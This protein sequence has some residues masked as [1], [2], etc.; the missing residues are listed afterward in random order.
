M[1][2][3]IST[4]K[5]GSNSRRKVIVAFHITDL[6]AE[7]PF[8]DENFRRE[9]AIRIFERYFQANNHPFQPS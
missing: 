2:I 1:P 4:E 5:T 9:K 6:E 8:G 7:K 3:L